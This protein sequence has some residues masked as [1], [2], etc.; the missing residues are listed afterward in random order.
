MKK[1]LIFIT[2][3]AIFIA[4]AAFAAR[5]QVILGAGTGLAHKL[6]PY[7]ETTNRVLSRDTTYIL[8]GWYFIDSTYSITIPA[9][10]LIRGDSGSAGSLIIKRGAHIYA[11]GT[12][13]APIV[14]TSNKPIGQRKPGDWGGVILL[15]SAPTNRPTNWQIEGGF[16]T[17]AANDASYGGSNPD[18]NTGIFKYCRIE[19]AGFAFA[20]DNE[21]NGLTLGGV[22]R[23]TTL[24]YIQVSFSN[25]DDVEMFGG[26]VDLKHYIGWR[27]LDDD[28]DT[29]LGWQGRVQFAYEVRDKNIFDASPPGSS[30]GFESDGEPPIAT[31]AVFP[32]LPHTGARV[33]NVTIIG[34]Q[35]DTSA[36]VNAKW[37]CVA[38]LRRGTYFSIYN[39]FMVGFPQ[40]V[41]LRDTATHRYVLEDSLQISHSSLQSRIKQI[42]AD[43]SP[44]T[45]FIGL[46]AASWFNDPAKANYGGTGGRNPSDV[47]VP[48]SAFVL[49]RTNNA[50][51]VSGSEADTG[52]T[53]FDGRLAGDA[54]F[55]TTARYRGCF[56]P[57]L[58]RDQQWDWGWSEYEPENYDPEATVSNVA[59]TVS[60]SWNMISLP[61]RNVDDA[62]VH[63]LFPGA[64][65]SAFSYS[66]SYTPRFTMDHAIGYWLKFGGPLSTNIVGSPA[67]ID[68]F[69]LGAKW[70]MV[71][72]V[73]MPVPIVNVVSNPPGNIVSNYF[74]YDGAYHTADTLKPGKAY[75]VKV[76]AAGQLY[77]DG[78]SNTS[79]PK[80]G[81]INNLLANLDRLTITDA[82]GK[83]QELYFGED[84]ANKIVPDKYELPPLPPPGGFDA[85]FSSGRMVEIT[86][87]GSQI[88]ISVQGGTYPLV[89]SVKGT[90][91]FTGLQLLE[92]KDGNIVGRHSI[93]LDG[94]A[95][96]S[97]SEF[98]RLVLSV[99]GVNILP[100]AF[101]LN[102]NFP[103]PFNPTTHF[104]IEV[105]QESQIEVSIYNV[106]GQKVATLLH[107][108]A[109]AGYH[110]L[111]WNAVNDNGTP[112][113]SGIY[114]V[115]M[116][117]DKFN[118][119]K[120]I[121][122]M[123]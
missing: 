15:G 29:D 13:E 17:T 30:E 66:G 61:M 12:K 87:G 53:A 31:P 28:I 102:Q 9:G 62:S 47:G 95:T 2:L 107:G 50:I 39:S 109:S 118:D 64:T 25:D 22:G 67:V 79:A 101:A 103:N 38:R 86:S 1:A 90:Q 63:A 51:P 20:Q 3:A 5:P 16:G 35:S 98:D 23:G 69:N 106:L 37:T 49:N 81:A 19:F 83:M 57:N 113:T 115:R 123:K 18:D 40:G 43:A 73:K 7:H 104:D 72:S 4:T 75:W 27:M 10:T 117:G 88:P 120:K 58:P 82:Q 119:V 59:Y 78:F 111:E 26:T 91:S 108:I 42:V 14:F 114:F 84:R 55:D 36:V 99:G 41:D 33:S 97:S 96:V 77:V 6:E 8:T 48:A 46:D 116:T 56:D 80:F 121:M 11:E 112:A 93:G 74:G 94:S 76:A 52:S 100:K 60:G 89:V 68:T 32:D 44:A 105:P 85:R 54:F 24:D 122:L 110:T 21:I 34:P 45:P 65:T 71:G 92:M 70:N